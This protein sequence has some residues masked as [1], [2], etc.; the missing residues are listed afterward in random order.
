MTREKPL[1]F[2]VSLT[3]APPVCVPREARATA[4]CPT[5]PAGPGGTE[6]RR[7]TSVA[8]ARAAAVA[9]LFT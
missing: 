5:R 3:T 6:K 9:A 2:S 4:F 8:P 7:G 1:A